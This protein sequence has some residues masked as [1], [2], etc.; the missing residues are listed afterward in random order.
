[1][2][3][4]DPDLYKRALDFAAREH[5]NQTVPGSGFPYVVHVAKV[6]MEVLVATEEEGAAVRNLALACAL[7]HDTIEDAEPPER[8]RVRAELLATFGPEVARGVEALTK[9]DAL[10]KAQRMADSLRRIRQQPRAVWFVKLADRITNLEPA[11]PSWSGE[12]RAAYAGEAW[13]ILVELGEASELLRR[14]LE[15]KLHEYETRLAAAAS[16]AGR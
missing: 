6:A 8:P 15:Q 10:P 11:P 16:A 14:R 2:A 1:M 7:L 5:G 12:K 3:S 13:S 4:F 9:N